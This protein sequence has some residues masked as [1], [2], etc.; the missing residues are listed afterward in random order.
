[1]FD[2]IEADNYTRIITVASILQLKAKLLVTDS[3][4]V[5]VESF[6]EHINTTYGIMSGEVI[7]QHLLQELLIK[8]EPDKSISITPDGDNYIDYL[9]E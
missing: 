4:T 7:M 2:H 6:V 1:M 3:D 8:V 5:N 9:T